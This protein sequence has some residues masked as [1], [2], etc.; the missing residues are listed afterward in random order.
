MRGNTLSRK[1]Q[2][3]QQQ[4]QDPRLVPSQGQGPD[5]PVD[6]PL[7]PLP[8]NVISIAREDQTEDVLRPDIFHAPAAP[9]GHGEKLSIRGVEIGVKEAYEKAQEMGLFGWPS[10]SDGYRWALGLGLHV[11]VKAI[12]D[13]RFSNELRVLMALQRGAQAIERE[14]RFAA[15]KGTLVNMIQGLI[16][17]GA[18]GDARLE[19]RRRVEEIESLN[20]E[21]FRVKMLD[22]V[23]GAF[24]GFWTEMELERAEKAEQE[25]GQEQD[26]DEYPEA[27]GA[28]WR[29]GESE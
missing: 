22:E 9:K 23:A 13:D 4:K 7:P 24:P 10:V 12:K 6:L 14:R 18:M 2:Q 28:D 21:N 11:I 27:D 15:M 8:A 16:E 3:Q 25:Q 20:V 26:Q 19:F 5:F 29:N 1:Q 17:D